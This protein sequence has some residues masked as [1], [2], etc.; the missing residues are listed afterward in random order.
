MQVRYPGNIS[1]NRSKYYN[2]IMMAFRVVS[3]QY[4]VLKLQFM[5]DSTVKFP[6]HVKRSDSFTIYH[7]NNRYEL[8][9]IENELTGCRKPQVGLIQF[10]ANQYQQSLGLSLATSLCRYSQSS[11]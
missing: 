8:F 3:M 2:P 1:S 11:P 4:F 10:P 6:E 7:S 5:I 9:K